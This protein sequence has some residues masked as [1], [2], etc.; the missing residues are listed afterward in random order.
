MCFKFEDAPRVQF[1]NA[2]ALLQEFKRVH[3]RSEVA[4]FSRIAQWST[5]QQVIY[6]INSEGALFIDTPM[7][8]IWF[9]A[10]LKK[11]L[12]CCGVSLRDLEEVE[13][14]AAL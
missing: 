3:E 13:L 4:R 14:I 5:W 11:A 2:K 1:S 7:V 9:G 12:C 8:R 10:L 6:K